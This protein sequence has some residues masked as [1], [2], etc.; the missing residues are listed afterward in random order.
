MTLLVHNFEVRNCE[1]TI[2]L[3]DSETM[4]PIKADALIT[5]PPYGVNFAHGGGCVTGAARGTRFAGDSCTGDNH[6]FD[7]TKWL[8]YVIV[9]LW[10][11]NHYAS[12]LPDSSC[13]LVWDK[14]DGTGNNDQ[15]DCELAWTNL[16]S[17]ARLKRHL[18]NGMLKDSEREERRVHPMQK[19]VVLMAW[20]MEQCKVPIGATVLD[21]CEAEETLL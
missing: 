11:A 16:D 18:W 21:P 1:A 20:T 14:R 10:G 19:P 5:D 9:A 15:A 7:P 13:W 4:E 6:P 8:G 2:I 3:G 12:K 17:P